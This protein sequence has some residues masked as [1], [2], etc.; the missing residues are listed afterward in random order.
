MARFRP[1]DPGSTLPG[2]VSPHLP[3]PGPARLISAPRHPASLP[4]SSGGEGAEYLES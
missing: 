2:G 1:N 3:R 4:I